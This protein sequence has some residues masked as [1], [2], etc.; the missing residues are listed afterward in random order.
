MNEV[1]KVLRIPISSGDGEGVFDIPMP[2]QGCDIS[3]SMQIAA[4]NSGVKYHTHH[5][6]CECLQQVFP[7]VLPPQ[8]I[9]VGEKEISHSMEIKPHLRIFISIKRPHRL[10]FDK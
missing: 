9:G 8:Y 6:C 5:N 3:R 4:P 2:L 10:D 1:P 7:E